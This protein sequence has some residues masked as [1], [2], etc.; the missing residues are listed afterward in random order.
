MKVLP[1]LICAVSFAQPASEP[2]DQVTEGPTQRLEI[3]L[4]GVPADLG[5]LVE[6]GDGEREE[7]LDNGEALR[8]ATLE[9]PPARSVQLRLLQLDGRS[10]TELWGGL[11]MLADHDHE[12]LSFSYMVEGQQPVVRR[13]PSSP[14]LHMSAGDE[15]AGAYRLAI[16]WGGLVLGYLAVLVLGWAIRGRRLDR[17]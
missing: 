17:T 5:V 15:P 3:Q 14:S 2:V 12:I 13:V 1:L 16:G 6:R 11:A 9:G 10:E 7:L 8:V 4:Y